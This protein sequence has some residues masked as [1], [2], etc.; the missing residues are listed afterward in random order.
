MSRDCHISRRLEAGVTNGAAR[1]DEQVEGGALISLGQ[2][3]GAGVGDAGFGGVAAFDAA[4]VEEFLA[5]R[6]RSAST[7]AMCAGGTT[8]IMPTPRLKDSSRPSVVHALPDFAVFIN[9]PRPGGQDTDGLLESF[10]LGVGM[11]LVVPPAHI[12]KS[13]PT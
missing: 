1:F 9:E 7:L 13:K 11:I 4:D 8:R 10:N 3:E 6:F 12:A 5:R 2:I